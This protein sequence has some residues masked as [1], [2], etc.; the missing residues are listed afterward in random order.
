MMAI[1]PKFQIGRKERRYFAT[2]TFTDRELP[3]EVFFNHLQNINQRSSHVQD[4]NVIVYYG[5]GGIGKTSLQKQL[6]LELTEYDSNA[7]YTTIDFK[8]TTFHSPARALLELVR[9]IEYQKNI[10]FPH[11]EIAYSLYFYKRN[12]DTTYNEKK[13]RFENEL[14]IIGSIIS[15]LDGLGIAGSI[16]GIVGKVYNSGKKWNLNKDVKEQ[17]AE[18]E[19]CS[20]QEIEERLIAF[21]A[22]DLQLAIEKNNIKH[23]VIFLDTFEA[24]W[25]SVTNKLTIHSKDKWV[26]ELIAS[27]PNVLFVICG[28]EY[29][30]WENY[31][32]D[33]KDILHHHII[34]N[35]SSKDADSFLENCGIQEASIREKIIS[36]SSGH[37]YHLDLSVDTYFEMKNRG[38]TIEVD[39]FGSNQR[40]ILDRFLQYLTDEEIETLKIMTI[41]GIIQGIY[42]SFYSNNIQLDMLLQDTMI[43]IN[44]PS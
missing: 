17:L 3:R 11:F 21:F 1:Q 44:S 14:S 16:T 40:E 23:A 5:V 31:D 30:E 18:L 10:T 36:S 38:E 32:A 22:Y 41:Q 4:Y 8:D 6:K 25:S 13:L 43:L 34:E 7:L 15:T 28:R 29:L 9:E 2:K 19:S 26:R 35:L 27:L 39:M 33:W 24:I 42:S 20:I 12:P 37:P